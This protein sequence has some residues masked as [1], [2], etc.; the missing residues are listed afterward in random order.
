[1]PEPLILTGATLIVGSGAVPVSG[2]A[3]VVQDGRIQAVV[4]ERQAPAGRTRRLDGLTLLLG[5]INLAV[6]SSELLRHLTNT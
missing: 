3:V 4:A 1:M 2:R 5:L 6:V